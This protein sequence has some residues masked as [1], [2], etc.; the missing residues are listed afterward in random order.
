MLAEGLSITARELWVA[1]RAISH[2]ALIVS[3]PIT[4]VRGTHLSAGDVHQRMDQHEILACFV[5]LVFIVRA[6]STGLHSCL[7]DSW[8]RAQASTKNR[9]AR[10]ASPTLEPGAQK[11]FGRGLASQAISCELRCEY[12]KELS[13]RPPRREA[14]LERGRPELGRSAKSSKSS[15]SSLE[16]KSQ[17]NSQGLKATPGQCGHLA[18][19]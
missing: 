17:R 2:V 10:Q 5:G 3:S 8:S 12:L 15:P 7:S 11:L 16:A 14:L 18:D 4:L 9:Y 6:L 1:G 19:S 13:E